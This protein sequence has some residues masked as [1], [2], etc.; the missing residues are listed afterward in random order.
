MI[1]T[2]WIKDLEIKVAFGNGHLM[3]KKCNSKEEL[4]ITWDTVQAICHSI[5]SEIK[6]QK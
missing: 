1:V 5:G 6:L 4:D 3:T 2:V